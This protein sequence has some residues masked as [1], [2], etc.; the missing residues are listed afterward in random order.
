[1]KRAWTYRLA[2][3]AAVVIL[4]SLSLAASRQ[5]GLAPLPK[6]ATTGGMSLTEALSKRRSC[7]A[8]TDKALTSDQIGQLCWAAQG[9]TEPAKG[10]RTAP[11]AM[12]LYSIHVYIVDSA[13][14][15]EYLPKEHS[16]KTLRTD[17]LV[18]GLQAL[19]GKPAGMGGAPTAMIL[20]MN[21]APL[22]ERVGARAEKFAAMEAGHIAE[23]VLLQATALGLGSIPVG[24][25][26]EAKVSDLLKLPEGIRPVYI[27][28]LGTPK[29]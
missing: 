27:L 12:T 18:P 13:G 17:D 8:Y 23:N 14:V 11:S 25:F 7:T 16:L 2:A 10:L 15:H 6:P 20:G 5:D 9:I 24:G 4:G 29:G 3:A 21:L 28:P 22:A 26:D 19:V 1:M